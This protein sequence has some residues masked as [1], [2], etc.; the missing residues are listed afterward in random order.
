MVGI[1]MRHVIG[2]MFRV[3]M[4]RVNKMPKLCG[5]NFFYL[6]C[7]FWFR[8]R[9]ESIPESRQDGNTALHF[10]SSK[11][12]LTAAEALLV[13]ANVNAIAKVMQY[14]VSQD[15]SFCAALI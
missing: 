13:M 11:G 4:G 9:L 3:Y 5:M 6:F 1:L 7:G 15:G 12:H 8:S 14:E 2:L 10:A